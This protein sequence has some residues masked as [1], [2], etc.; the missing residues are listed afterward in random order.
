[1]N[2]DSFTEIFMAFISA[3]CLLVL[4]NEYVVEANPC[5]VLDLT[6]KGFVSPLKNEASCQFFIDALHQNEEAPFYS[7]FAESIFNSRF[8]VLLFFS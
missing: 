6:G 5:P 1:M 2:N 3:F 8:R 7:W 4:L